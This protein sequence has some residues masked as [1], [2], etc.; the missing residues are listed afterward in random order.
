MVLRKEKQYARNYFDRRLDS[1]AGGCNTHV[2]SQPT[3]GLLPQRT[4]GCDSGDSGHPAALGSALGGQARLMSRAEDG[5][6]S[7]ESAALSL[8]LIKSSV[9]NS[10]EPGADL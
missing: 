8:H 6:K 4:A 10:A 2:A 1:D 7:L 9:I 5:N 3:M